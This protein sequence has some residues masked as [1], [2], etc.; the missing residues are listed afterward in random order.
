MPVKVGLADRTTEPVPVVVAALI[1]VPLP[2][3]IPVI[4][5]ESVIAGVV[6]AVAT[7]PASPFALTT[8]TVVTVPELAVPFAAAVIKP[9]A[10]TVILAFVK[11]PTFELTV[12]SVVAREPAVVVISP[13]K[14]GKLVA[15][16][17]PVTPVAKG[18]PVAAVKVNEVGVPKAGVTSVGLVAKTT[19]PVPVID[20]AEAAVTNPLALTVIVDIA[21]VPTLPFTVAKVRAAEAEPEAGPAVASPVNWLMALIVT[22]PV[23]PFTD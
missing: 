5:V 19:L 4:V 22:T 10:F 21:K 6:L 3:N 2:C 14:A 7:V 16:R 17:V 11:E 1:A 8:D 20:A 18:R 13:V 23:C 12:A 9:L 15:A